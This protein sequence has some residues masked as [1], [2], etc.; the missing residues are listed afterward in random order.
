MIRYLAVID[1][2]IVENIVIA[3]EAF[4]LVLQDEFDSVV[5]VTDMDPKPSPGDSYYPE[6]GAFVPNTIVFNDLSADLDA[7][8]MQQGTDDGFEPFA[9]SKYSVSYADGIVTIGCK[10]Y[11]APGLLD[12][13]H[14]FLVER[15]ANVQIFTSDDT[16]PAH[17][18][19]G[20]TWDDAQMLY[21]ALIKVKF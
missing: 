20:I 12:V 10:Q 16:G 5:D 15:E 21:D 2:G 6:T 1:K 7:L 8:H 4:K 14:K 9:I 17:G 3:D 13:L 18:K 19:Y 11:P